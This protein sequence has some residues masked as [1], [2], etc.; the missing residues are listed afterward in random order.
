MT[1]P[2]KDLLLQGF[3]GR[4]LV[5][6]AGLQ[7]WLSRG[8]RFPQRVRLEL[9]A[10]NGRWIAAVDDA[11]STVVEATGGDR[12]RTCRNV[13]AT[14]PLEDIQIWRYALTAG[15]LGAFGSRDE[16]EPIFLAAESRTSAA[17]P[18]L[19]EALVALIGASTAKAEDLFP[20][21]EGAWPIALAIIEDMPAVQAREKLQ[22]VIEFECQN[23]ESVR[24]Q[25]FKRLM[26]AVN[27]IVSRRPDLRY[28]L[29]DFD[30]LPELATS[31][32]DDVESI[33]S[34]E[35]VRRYRS[36]LAGQVALKQ[37]EA[38]RAEMRTMRLRVRQSA[39][40]QRVINAVSGLF[41]SEGVT[42]AR[43]WAAVVRS[44]QLLAACTGA[45]K[46]ESIDSAINTL[47]KSRRSELEVI[48]A[49]GVKVPAQ[50][51]TAW[52]ESSGVALA[53]LASP[54]TVQCRT[55]RHSISLISD[56]ESLMS[57]IEDFATAEYLCAS[58]DRALLWSVAT[59][60]SLRIWDKVFLTQRVIK[61]SELDVVMSWLQ[62]APP[63]IRDQFD[64]M[65][66]SWLTAQALRPEFVATALTSSDESL[67]SML[68][69]ATSV[70][71]Y[72]HACRAVAAAKKS[73][74]KSQLQADFRAFINKNKVIF[75]G[76]AA[77]GV[78]ALGVDRTV[79][80]LGVALNKHRLATM[81]TSALDGPH[82]AQVA[83][84]VFR[85]VNE[86]E[87]SPAKTAWKSLLRA[88][89]DIPPAV[90]QAIWSGA[91]DSGTVSA[92]RLVRQRPDVFV[93][94]AI[95]GL[96][97][98]EL[99]VAAVKCPSLIAHI[100]GALNSAQ[101]LA[102]LTP[103]RNLLAKRPMLRAVLE[104]AAL[105]DLREIPHL[106][107]LARTV[108]ARRALE[109]GTRFD[110]RYRTYTLPKRSGGTREISVPDDRLK[111][112]HRRLLSGAFDPVPLH[113]ASHGFRNG[114]SILTNARV[115][116]GCRLVL[117]VDIKGFFPNTT[118][119]R[120]LTACM[121]VDGGNLSVRGA[122]L[123]ADICCYGGAL[124]TGAPTSPAIGNLVLRGADAAISKAATTSG[125]N[126]TR[127]AD[128]LTFSDDGAAKRIIPFVQRVLGE[129]GYELD[130]KKTQL[131]RRGRQ[132]LVTNLV[133]ND[134]VN[135]R[136]SD[137][138]RIRAAVER[139]CAG[140][141]VT[142]H[143]KPMDDQSLHGRLALLAM[144]DPAPAANY[145]RRLE[146]EASGWGVRRG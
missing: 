96:P 69:G 7:R 68:L 93:P 101:V 20:I 8:V 98:E 102:A 110:D 91:L 48:P 67:R 22:E 12:L 64:Q 54:R 104:L 52:P 141:E 144:I 28:T 94:L 73:S 131:Y 124:P 58:K 130:A 36:R 80:L 63:D 79:T 129:I 60:R 118:Y 107:M 100:G 31:A 14:A 40:Q 140:H 27:G 78:D 42:S 51:R 47:L 81:F 75:D 26:S 116:V 128:D 66:G 46:R 44:F 139:R 33:L 24:Q 61:D 18:K 138:R 35:S 32:L 117:N 13:L 146:A 49:A 126:Y 77:N 120:V 127:Y 23:Y 85:I 17:D 125:I 92:V 87:N 135:L 37:R 72:D 90:V 108:N 109:P 34:P 2:K 106:R 112:L 136:R 9:E 103:A 15:A 113:D 99:L 3:H 57:V 21:A 11:V 56:C 45:G 25:K 145:R 83:G 39:A 88:G 70:L 137:R 55:K 134:R 76:L 53:F 10:G 29:R 97:A 86:S 95:N 89:S 71:R 41:E 50:L 121:K 62:S 19:Q 5:S 74:A 1:K 115:H 30:R 59:D 84:F 133:V 111:R 119:S 122:K 142:W 105:S 82:L 143:G 114:R 132:Q 38:A 4:G 65:H 16:L 123:L 6:L 43:R